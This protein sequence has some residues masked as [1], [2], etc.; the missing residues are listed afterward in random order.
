MFKL[1]NLYKYYNKPED[2]YG[3]KEVVTVKDNTGE[4]RFVL[5][6]L[7]SIDDKP[8]GVG[9]GGD[10]WHKN[11]K[12]HRDD[13]KPAVEHKNGAKTWYKNGKLHR[14]D[15]KPAIKHKNGDEAWYKNGKLH[16]DDDKPAIITKGFY[17][18]WYKNGIKIKQ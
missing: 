18:E 7:T 1:F 8:S 4:Q 11:G 2:L 13:D 5:G 14:D 16:R 3:S 9:V 10:Y 12:L 15:D 17:K 6:A